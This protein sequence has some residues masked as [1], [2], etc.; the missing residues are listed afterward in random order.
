MRTIT[1][2][3][4]AG[5]KAVKY[6]DVFGLQDNISL[7]SEYEGKTFWIYDFY[8]MHPTCNCNNVYL[9]FINKDDKA[10]FGV[11]YTFSTNQFIVEDSTF[12]KKEA[13]DIAEDTLNNSSQAIE[14]FK[15]R[16]LQMKQEGS[17]IL[18]KA[19]KKQKPIQVKELIGRNDPCTCGSGKKYKKCCGAAL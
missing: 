17:A 8:C 13:R 19:E 3:E 10:E 1:A 2:E 7:K 6:I 15:Q 12:A 18:V 9:K 11:R 4:V 16:Y 14:L 5:G